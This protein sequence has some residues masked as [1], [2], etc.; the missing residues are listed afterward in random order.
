MVVVDN[1]EFQFLPAT[2]ASARAYL[3]LALGDVPA[4]IKYARL[5]LDLLPKGDHL[6]RGTPASLLALASWTCGDLEAAEQSL[7]DAISSFQ[8]AGNILF[9]IT[10]A[11][12]LADIRLTLGRLR[13]AFDTY[14]QSLQLAADAGQV[15]ALGNGRPAHRVE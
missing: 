7:A 6:R 3:A 2:I 11:F 8:Q 12:H 10:G 9:A 13:Q 4:T 14:Q 1:G 5:A 15:R